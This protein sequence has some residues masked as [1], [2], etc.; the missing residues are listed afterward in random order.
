MLNFLKTGS[1]P[2]ITE[3]EKGV[4]IML[5]EKI[6]WW[7]FMIC[8]LLVEC[9]GVLLVLDCIAIDS[10]QECLGGLFILLGNCYATWRHIKNKPR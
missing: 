4:S 5:Q 8:L 3:K 7:V 2:S 10:F 6:E 9:I 1:D